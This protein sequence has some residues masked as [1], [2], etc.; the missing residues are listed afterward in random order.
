M[1]LPRVLAL[2]LGVWTGLAAGTHAE[3]V[4]ILEDDGLPARPLVLGPRHESAEESPAAPVRVGKAPPAPIAERPTTDRP[5]PDAVWI[6]GYWSWL[7]ARGDYAW[8]AGTWRVPPPGRFWV[9]GSWRRDDAGWLRTPGFWSARQVD[10]TDWH[11]QG[12]P[13]D[14]P[15]EEVG[16]APGPDSF[17]VAGHFAPDGDGVAWKPGFWTKSQP[18]WEW[19]PA[20]WVRLG[21]GWAY[22]EGRWSHATT[23]TAS[24]TATSTATATALVSVAATRPTPA[25]ESILPTIEEI[26][27]TS[28]SP[29]PTPTP[30]STQ[31]PPPSQTPTVAMTPSRLPT[32]TPTRTPT[33]AVVATAPAP[34]PALGPPPEELIALADQLAGEAENFV[35]AISANARIINHS[36]YFISEGLRIRDSALRLRQAAATDPAGVARELRNLDAGWRNLNSRL[37]PPS[38]GGRVGP[39]VARALRMG[40]TAGR[41]LRRGR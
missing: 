30:K 40:A 21:D 36:G 29:T 13:S 19:T 31:P 8:V 2:L 10:R 5:A 26:P 12:P 16:P 34:V 35:Q 6:E 20:L 27:E 25:D 1:R 17:L 33:V 41:I 32:Q 24:S 22:R 11:A 14:A 38:P 18:G 3:D 23:A 37:R 28:P 15:A 4:A 39:F 7:P 9:N